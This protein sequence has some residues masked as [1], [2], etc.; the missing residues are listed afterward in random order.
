PSRPIFSGRMPGGA[1]AL[2]QMIERALA[3]PV[4]APAPGPVPAVATASTAAPTSRH[5]AA[6]SGA[7]TEGLARH[8]PGLVPLDLRCPYSPA[9]EFPIARE[10]RLPIPARRAPPAGGAIGVE[11]LLIASAWA[12]AHAP[13]IRK[14]LGQ[15]PSPADPAG[16]PISH[17]FV[18]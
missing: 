8:L 12:A 10:A 17:L 16:P 13:L 7:A 15:V 2:I 4:E 18:D 6:T 3:E 5:P 1:I 11:P 9:A 14:S